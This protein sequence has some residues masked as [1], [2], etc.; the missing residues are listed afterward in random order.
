MASVKGAQR[1]GV[2]NGVPD[3]PSEVGPRR[4]VLTIPDTVAD[5]PPA[6]AA[7][8]ALPD[9][10]SAYVCRGPVC[11]APLHTLQLLSAELASG[12]GA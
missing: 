2:G 11:S 9:R 8:A 3:M 6:L 10:V 1:R 12:S 5:L 7:K 4:V